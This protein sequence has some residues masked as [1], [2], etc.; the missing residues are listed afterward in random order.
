MKLKLVSLSIVAALAAGCATEQGTHTAVGTG[1]GAAVGAG[2]GN[3]IGGN[4]KGT[5]IGAAVGAAAG[6][7]LGYNWN[8]IRGK[9]SRDTAGTGTQITEQPDGSLK[10]NIPSQVT[11]DTDSATIK[12]S[13][14][15][16]LDQ[17][18][19]TL[20][21]HQDVNATVIGHTDSTGNPTYNMQLSQRRAQ[22]VA[23]YL[24]DRGVARNRLSAE[25]RG[26]SQP[27][28]D[29]ATEAG[30]AQNRRVEIF[31]KPIQG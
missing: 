12:P 3:L 7:A 26:Q 28:A 20:S 19:Q 29:N 8:A 17:V 5:V 1:A 6:G 15:S 11:F 22:S 27:I 30:R 2:L 10:V 4:T 23:G 14:R 9:L 18:A 25:G 24:G 31:L 16:V 13:F 21:Q